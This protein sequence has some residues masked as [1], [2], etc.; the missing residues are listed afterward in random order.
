MDSKVNDEFWRELSEKEKKQLY[1]YHRLVKVM[2]ELRGPEG[3]DWDKEQTHDSL[4]PYLIEETY[5]VLERLEKK[6]TQGLVEE[7]GD[8][9]LQI[10]FHSQIADENGD[11]NI[12]HVAK[13]IAD[14]LVRRH[15]HIFGDTKVDNVEQILKNWEEIKV[16]EKKDQV[17]ESTSILDSVNRHQPALLEAEELQTKA[18]KVGFDWDDVFGAIEKVEEELDEVKLAL[19]EEDK[20]EAY[21]EIGDL[22]FSVVNVAG[23][24]GCHGELVLRNTNQKFRQR[25]QKVEEKVLKNNQKI[26][27]T[28]LE[29][30]DKYW[31][32]AKIEERNI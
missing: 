18:A 5:E 27:E 11:F 20:E 2:E 22:F 31:D 1:Q 24:A 17:K 30:L 29:I 6:D 25:F 9:L 14:K 23:L 19:N 4:K 21:K 13:G 15:P 26:E 28:P 16:E 8:L 7:L 32:E 10:V 3:C 12:E